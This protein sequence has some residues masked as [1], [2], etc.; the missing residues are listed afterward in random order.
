MSGEDLYYGG[1][2][3]SR[4]AFDDSYVKFDESEHLDTDWTDFYGNVKEAIPLN[5]PEP[6]GK[7]VQSTCFIYADHARDHLMRRLCTGVLCYLKLTYCL[8]L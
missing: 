7:P 6:R 5:V 4:I 1:H 3:R 8:A 2:E